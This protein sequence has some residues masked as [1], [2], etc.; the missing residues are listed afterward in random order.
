MTTAVADPM[1]RSSSSGLV[2]RLAAVASPIAQHHQASGCRSRGNPD[3]GAVGPVT[4]RQTPRL[5]RATR[6]LTAIAIASRART[7]QVTAAGTR[8]GCSALGAGAP[9][10]RPSRH[11]G[12]SRWE[13][14]TAVRWPRGPRWP[15]S[16]LETQRPTDR[17]S[18]AFAAFLPAES[19]GDSARHW[20]LGRARAAR[21]SRLRRRRWTRSTRSIRRTASRSGSRTATASTSRSNP[22]RRTRPS[23]TRSATGSTTTW[24]TR[25]ATATG[26]ATPWRSP[27]ARRRAGRSHPRHGPAAT[28]SPPSRPPGRSAS[29]R[30]RT[31]RSTTPSSRRP[32]TVP[33]RRSTGTR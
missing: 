33:S 1:R 10:Q 17:P 6:P 23:E 12:L 27:A 22:I 25:W 5:R 7:V 15:L 28:T 3:K 4:A 21:G 24:A 13:T 11:W 30:R 32:T 14:Q 9:G 20:R 2:V 8:A 26:W 16:L 18:G 29:R 19:P 31:S